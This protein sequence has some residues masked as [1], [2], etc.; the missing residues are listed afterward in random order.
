MRRRPLAGLLLGVIAAACSTMTPEQEKRRAILWDAATGC[1]R[2]TSAIVVT[3][4]DHLEGVHY[5]LMQGGKQD[6][7]AFLECYQTTAAR[8]LRDA[9]LTK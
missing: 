1:A 4:I 2:G 6:V 8:N 5:T 3:D 7:P 9:G